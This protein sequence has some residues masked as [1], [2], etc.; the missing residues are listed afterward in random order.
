MRVSVSALDMYQNGTTNS[1]G[2][3]IAGTLQNTARGI[4]LGDRSPAAGGGL[5]GFIAEAIVYDNDISNANLNS[6]CGYLGG[7]WGINWVNI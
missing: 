7:K 1:V 2:N 6:L 5:N 4:I 3:A